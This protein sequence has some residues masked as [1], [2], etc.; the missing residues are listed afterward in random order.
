MKNFRVKGRIGDQMN[1]SFIF[2]VW[3]ILHWFLQFGLGKMLLYLIILYNFVPHISG[4]L[5]WVVNEI[6]G[7]I[8]QDKGKISWIIRGYN[9]QLFT[10]VS[11]S[12]SRLFPFCVFHTNFSSFAMNKKFITNK[13]YFEHFVMKRKQVHNLLL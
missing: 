3:K 7:K 2:D 8:H 11:Y 13:S 1:L 9:N 12:F 5:L 6:T 10:R 4:S